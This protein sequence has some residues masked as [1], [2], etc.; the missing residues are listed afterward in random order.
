MEQRRDVRRRLREVEQAARKS[1]D[2]IAWDGRRGRLCSAHGELPQLGDERVALRLGAAYAR[3]AHRDG[4]AEC[5][6]RVPELY[7]FRLDG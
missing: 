4:E 3:V 5:H 2:T 6:D 1:G 7:F